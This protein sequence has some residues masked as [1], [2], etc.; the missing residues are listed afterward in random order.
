VIVVD[1]N[2]LANHC[3]PGSRNT[4]TERLLQFDPEW[5]APVLW[6]SE[7]RNLLCGYLRRGEMDL[8]KAREV[9]ADAAETLKGGEHTVSDHAVMKLVMQ[10]RCTA[11]DCEFAALAAALGTVLV[12]ED[13]ALLA[14]FPKLCRSLRQAIR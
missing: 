9:F 1:T 8:D 4:D 13:K 7:F 11:Y 3:L 6:R 2:L 5:A 10:S 12:T 14:A